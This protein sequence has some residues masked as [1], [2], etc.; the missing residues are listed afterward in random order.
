L[1]NEPLKR[2]F[3]F[4]PQGS[5]ILFLISFFA[6]SFFSCDP[7]GVPTDTSV[8]TYKVIYDGNGATSGS[9]P[10][11]D[12]Q[13]TPDDEV[14]VKENTGF[15]SKT[16]FSFG[17]WSSNPEGDEKSYQPGDILKIGEADIQLYAIWNALPEDPV[18]QG[19]NLSTVE[20]IDPASFGLRMKGQEWLLKPQETMTVEADT[21]I[22]VDSFQWYLDGE[23]TGTNKNKIIVD[24]AALAPSR[25]TIAVVVSKDKLTASASYIFHVA[26]SIASTGFEDGI[27]PAGSAAYNF[28]SSG[29][30]IGNPTVEELW[31]VVSNESNSGVKSIKTGSIADGESAYLKIPIDIPL[32]RVLTKID[33]WYKTS[34]EEG[35]DVLRFCTLLQSNSGT[36][37][38]DR[39]AHFS[40]EKNWTHFSTYLNYSAFDGLNLVFYYI[41]NSF[42]S[43]GQ[44]AAWIDD[45][46][47]TFIAE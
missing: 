20:L 44:D 19:I 46:T 15:L 5:F 10:V 39:I 6:L 25:H 28:D 45:I 11:D 2:R 23:K 4:L 43:E 22:D 21:S 18:N 24:A 34:T 12:R 17:G 3:H 14:V 40:G 27:L 37:T 42:L 47:L 29:V 30:Y 26:D 9:P 35:C 7:T 31:R 16:E 36:N 8:Q 33:F 13:Y 1:K 38:W 41:K 32:E